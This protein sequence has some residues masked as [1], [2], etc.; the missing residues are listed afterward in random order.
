MKING[1]EVVDAR[2][3]V[4]IEITPSDIK[5]GSTKDAAA[6]AAA[7]SCMRQLSATEARVHLGRTYVKQDKKWVRYNTGYA[8][9]SEIV[10]FDR[11]GAF[12]P[13]IYVL[14]P[15]QPSR[16]D[17]GKR[18]GTAGSGKRTKPLKKRSTPHI[19]TGVRQHGANR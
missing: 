15:I 13:G 19:V 9:R 10:A 6:C 1:I 7:L 5:K 3:K 12:E 11:G 4:K 14:S 8:L 17:S 18:Q 16:R 2:K